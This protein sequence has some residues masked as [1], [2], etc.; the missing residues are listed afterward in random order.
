MLSQSAVAFTM[1]LWAMDRGLFWLWEAIIHVQVPSHT[2]LL[3]LFFFLMSLSCC[4]PNMLHTCEIH[5][6]SCFF[7]PIRF[8]VFC[9]YFKPVLP[10]F[11]ISP[12]IH[13]TYPCQIDL[14]RVSLCLYYSFSNILYSFLLSEISWKTVK[15]D[16]GYLSHTVFWSI[17]TY[18]L[19]THS[20]PN[21]DITLL[22]FILWSFTVTLPRN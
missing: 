18:V 13:P 9:A 3:L 17:H 22:V 16:K 21:T 2:Q 11:Y 10:L 6:H 20:T 4:G 15:P 8:L 12:P 1:F 7:L 19:C 14:P 5:M